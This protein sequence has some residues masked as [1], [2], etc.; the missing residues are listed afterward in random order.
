[1]IQSTSQK[2]IAFFEEV[3]TYNESNILLF[4]SEYFPTAKINPPFVEL[5]E[6]IFDENANPLEIINKQKIVS[7]WS[8]ILQGELYKSKELIYQNYLKGTES[9]NKVY[10]N[11]IFNTI[12]VII[13]K[14]EKFTLNPSCLFFLK[15]IIGFINDRLLLPDMSPFLWESLINK[16][17]PYLEGTNSSH[18]DLIL[19]I[20]DYMEGKNELGEQILSKDDFLLLLKYTIFL[21]ENQSVPEI[22]KQ[23]EP[24]LKNGIISFSY[25]VL[26]KELYD[27]KKIKDCFIDFLKKVFVCFKGN[28]ISSIRSQFG[29]KTRFYP[30]DFLSEIIKKYSS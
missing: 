5:S 27:S 4:I 9:Q 6:M 20:F 30:P 1:M 26:H 18:K 21:V 8:S 14:G 12:K 11:V 10:L 24:K 25:W 17:E 29:S 15:E 2:P 22:Q 23:L 28:E 16:E 3:A 7:F 13:K 19:S